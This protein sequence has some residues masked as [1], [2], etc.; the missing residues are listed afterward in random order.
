[1]LEYGDNPEVLAYL[2]KRALEEA[3]MTDGADGGGGGGGGDGARGTDDAQVGMK[4]GAQAGRGRG[5]N[6]RGRS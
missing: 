1:M 4:R 6:K 3:A 5:T 2:N